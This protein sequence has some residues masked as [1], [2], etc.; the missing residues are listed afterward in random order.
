MNI[1]IPKGDSQRRRL[2][3][4]PTALTAWR[5]LHEF[6]IFRLH[7]VGRR[8][9]VTPLHIFNQAFKRHVIN[10]LASLPFIVNL[11]FLPVSS[12]EYNILNLF[13]IFPEWRVQ[14]EIILSGQS[15]QNRVGKAFFIRAG[16]P[17][18]HCDG[19]LCNAKPP[20]RNHQLFIK[21]HL[22]PQPKTFRT[23]AEW[24]VKRKAPGFN[25]VHADAAVRA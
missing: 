22:V 25:L 20:V 5:D 23:S 21:F 19:S 8:L 12:V 11:Y 13:G 17:S 24:I 1:L 14:R 7:G 10:S 4:L 6:F 2:K 15:I 9:A 18:H 16:L 3:P